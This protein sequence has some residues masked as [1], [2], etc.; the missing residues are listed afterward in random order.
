MIIIDEAVDASDDW[1]DTTDG[2]FEPIEHI[3]WQAD[4]FLIE[5]AKRIIDDEGP[6]THW[7]AWETFD[8][9]EDRD[10]AFRALKRQHPK[11][12]TRRRDYFYSSDRYFS[13]GD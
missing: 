1:W 10:I 3:Q 8:S 11:W 5:R 4:G 7:K 6:Y 2:I 9:G 13:Y 12:R